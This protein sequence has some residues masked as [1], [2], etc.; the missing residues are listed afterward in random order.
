VA[1]LLRRALLEHIVLESTTSSFLMVVWR[2]CGGSGIGSS[3]C[4]GEQLYDGG[5]AE[6]RW[7]HH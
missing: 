3:F 4:H 2:S 5:V 1:T 6:L 7:F